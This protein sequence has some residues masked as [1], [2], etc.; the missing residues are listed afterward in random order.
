[1][2]I[3]KTGPR[4][5]SGVFD[6]VPFDGI[7]AH[8]VEFF[9]DFIGGINVEVVETRLPEARMVTCAM[10]EIDRDFLSGL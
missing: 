1:L 9:A 3:Q 6:E 8:A 2:I 4:P 10:F 5:I 7:E